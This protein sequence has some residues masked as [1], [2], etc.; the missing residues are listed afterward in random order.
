M[1]LS[2]RIAEMVC[3]SA[4]DS[5]SLLVRG[6]D[7]FT[8]QAIATERLRP[9]VSYSLA[10][11]NGTLCYPGLE[12]DPR[13]HPNNHNELT[14]YIASIPNEIAAFGK[15]LDA[16]LR[17]KMARHPKLY[18]RLATALDWLADGYRETNTA[19][20]VAKIAS[21]LDVLSAGGKLRGIVEMLENLTGWQRSG[22]V[23]TSGNQSLYEVVKAIYDN[24]RSKILHGTYVDR[25]QSF[26]LQKEQGAKLARIALIEAA[27]RLANYEGE[28][29]DKGFRN[30]PYS[31]AKRSSSKPEV[32]V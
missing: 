17:P 18:M 1:Q 28:D 9:L 7:V 19:T 23:F 12:S 25:L 4:L 26:S 24:G 14:K 30:L 15:M 32:C 27:L 22:V 5:V 8:R 31:E 6:E 10:E 2:R 11:V 13:T 3:K 21:S 16:I 29:S 20:A